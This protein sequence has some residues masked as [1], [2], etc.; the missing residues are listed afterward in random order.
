MRTA[1]RW[2][3]DA[4]SFYLSCMETSSVRNLVA[5]RLLST[6]YTANFKYPVTLEQRSRYRD[7]VMGWR[8]EEPFDFRQGQEI[9]FFSKASRSGLDTMQPPIQ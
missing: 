5:A 7:G 2:T 4:D 1:I 3:P 9:F 6:G 8:T